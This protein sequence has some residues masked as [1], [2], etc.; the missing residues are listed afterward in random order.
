MLV[1]E[2]TVRSGVGPLRVAPYSPQRCPSGSVEVSGIIYVT[3]LLVVH[4]VVVSR[5]ALEVA[6]VRSVTKISVIRANASKIWFYSS[7]ESLPKP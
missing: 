7:W 3:S 4:G 1:P 6:E 2:E 5:D